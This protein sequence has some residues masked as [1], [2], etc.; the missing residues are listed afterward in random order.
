M[1]YRQARTVVKR[2]EPQHRMSDSHDHVG[3]REVLIVVAHPELGTFQVHWAFDPATGARRFVVQVLHKFDLLVVGYL[4]SLILKSGYLRV[5][6]QVEHEG[7]CPT[8]G[9]ANDGKVEQP[10]GITSDVPSLYNRLEGRL[11]NGFAAVSIEGVG[12]SRELKQRVQSH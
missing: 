2:F 9:K 10:R 6:Q 3:R 11:G 8:F 1:M 7:G 4:T 12:R 5:S